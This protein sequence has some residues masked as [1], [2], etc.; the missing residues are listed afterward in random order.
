LDVGGL[1]GDRIGI[2]WVTFDSTSGRVGNV[3]SRIFVGVANIDSNSV[4]VS[5]DAGKTC[6]FLEILVLLLSGTLGFNVSFVGS[7]VAGQPMVYLPHKG[8]LSPGE[9]ALYVSY[10]NGAGPF[11]GIKGA[12]FRYSITD[13]KWTDITPATGS[14]LYFGFGGLSID[15]QKPGTVMVA[16]LNSW[17]P[18][19]QIFRSTDSGKTWSKLWEWAKPSGLVSH[20]RLRV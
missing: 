8:V 17:N 15:L 1:N 6:M 14:D 19:A 11:D 3:T 2:T 20:V 16:A 12:V 10:G 18:D 13:S 4:F 9:K 7:A 5:N